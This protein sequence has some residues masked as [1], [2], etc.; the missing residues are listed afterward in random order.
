[1]KAVLLNGSP[2]INGNTKQ[3]LQI[4]AAELNARD[5][6]TEIIQLGGKTFAGCRACGLCGK[7]RDG[8]CAVD[9]GMNEIIGRVF[10]ADAVVIGSPTYFANVTAEV[11]AFIDRC[12]YVSRS[13]GGLL[14]YKPGAAVVIARRAGA[15]FVYAAINFFFGIAEMPI[16]ASSYWNMSLAR[17]PGDIQKDEEGIATFKTLG[18]N[19]A[20][21]IERK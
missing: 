3:A 21:L 10:A 1:M 13:C 9:D 6:E 5:I 12:G 4:V 20:R 19:L 8:K 14:K 11:K 18:E 16:A 7:T 17:L 15:D 2:R